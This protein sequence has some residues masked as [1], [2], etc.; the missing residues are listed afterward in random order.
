MVI[1][2]TIS[3]CINYY[4]WEFPGRLWDGIF[5][6]VGSDQLLSPSE[7]GLISTSSASI[8]MAP[9]NKINVPNSKTA[10]YSNIPFPPSTH[11][12]LKSL[13]SLESRFS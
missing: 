13:F 5:P 7:M 11:S 3:D 10:P 8:S 2:Q 1:K 9:Q 4:H 12:P 6:L